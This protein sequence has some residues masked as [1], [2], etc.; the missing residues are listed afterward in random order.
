MHYVIRWITVQK[1]AHTQRND[2][3]NNNTLW[4]LACRRETE[5]LLLLSE[6]SAAA[7]TFHGLLFPGPAE[8]ALSILDLSATKC[9]PGVSAKS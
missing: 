6:D 2:N 8:S 7:V 9:A 1:H 4:D 5:C 3:V